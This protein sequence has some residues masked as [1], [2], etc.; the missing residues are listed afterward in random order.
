M[1]LCYISWQRRGLCAL[2][3]MP[4]N[5]A[6]LDINAADGVLEEFPEIEDWYIGGHSL[7][8]SMVTSYALDHAEDYKG[9]ILP[10]AYAAEGEDI[11]QSGLRVISAYGD[12]DGVLDMEKYRDNLKNLP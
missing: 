1:R 2:V 3:R 9:L 12:K 6:V 11:R 5:L 10:A 4:C 8:D 7:G